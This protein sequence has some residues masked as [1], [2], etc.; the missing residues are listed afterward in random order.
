MAAC[1]VK[2]A[3]R[4]PPSHD[5]IGALNLSNL[6]QSADRGPRGSGSWGSVGIL[7]VMSELEGERA[8]VEAGARLPLQM[9]LSYET[10]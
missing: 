5:P 1:N 6:S 4:T 7:S 3:R 10:V 9:R 2:H 8:D